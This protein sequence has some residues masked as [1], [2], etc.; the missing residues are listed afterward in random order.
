MVSD[1]HCVEGQSCRFLPRKMIH[2]HYS[3]ERSSRSDVI[4]PRHRI[5]DIDSHEPAI[6]LTIPCTY[7]H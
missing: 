5:S 1:H 6:I 4:T 2:L 3:V 7:A